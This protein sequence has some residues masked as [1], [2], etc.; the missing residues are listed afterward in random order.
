M[1]HN[2]KELAT[3]LVALLNENDRSNNEKVGLATD[4]IQP[5]IDAAELNEESRD[6][7]RELL[8]ASA[9]ACLENAAVLYA[10][11]YSAA[12][13]SELIRFNSSDVGRKSLVI[14]MQIAKDQVAF[15]REFSENYLEKFP[16]GELVS[17]DI[18]TPTEKLNESIVISVDGGLVQDIS[19]IPE[20]VGVEVW[21]YDTEG[22]DEERIEED[23]NGNEFVRSEY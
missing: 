12:E 15:G 5:M 1:I 22:M 11:Y 23:D 17:F 2:C 3:E 9:I 6:Y 20:G 16:M 7:M 21:D 18:T 14:G 19:G 4:I 10:K 8:E 13:L